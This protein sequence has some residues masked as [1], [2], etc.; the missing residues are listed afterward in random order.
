M[1]S[2]RGYRRTNTKTARTLALLDT[3]GVT[4]RSSEV[5]LYVSREA[6]DALFSNAAALGV[7]PNGF[8]AFLIEQSLRKEAAE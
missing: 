8:A 6:R 4:K 3:V 2:R 5:R 7:F 1:R